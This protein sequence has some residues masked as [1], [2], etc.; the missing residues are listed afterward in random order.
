M[1]PETRQALITA[2]AT[3]SA[4]LVAIWLELP[5]PWWAAISAFVVSHADRYRLLSKGIMRVVGTIAGAFVGYELAL[6]TEGALVLQCIVLFLVGFFLTRERFRSSYSY[7]WIMGMMVITMLLFVSI[8]EPP[9]L[10][11]FAHSR[12]VEIALGVSL[13]TL[14]NAFL[15][16]AVHEPPDFAKGPKA[17]LLSLNRIGVLAGCTAVAIPLVW[18]WLE[19]PSMIQV[20]VTVLVMLD[21]NILASERRVRLR[22]LGCL[23][24]GSVGLAVVSLELNSLLL[25]GAAFFVSLFFFARIHHG[26][27]PW[28]YFGT[29]GAF[30]LILT[31]V[32]GSGPPDSILPVIDRFAG[33]GCGVVLVLVLGAVLAPLRP[34]PNRMPQS[35]K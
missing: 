26:E 3:V 1:Q 7:A 8:M 19:L 10:R 9:A 24:G 20:A 5:D 31:F 25:W 33:I 28:A 32:T 16:G 30:A 15:S 27:G 23:C 13:S 35:V 4:V 14:L 17:P 22:I 12:V 34:E 29:Q 11:A 2:L 18:S 6:W 21:R